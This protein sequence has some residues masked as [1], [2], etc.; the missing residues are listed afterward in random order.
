VHVILPWR[1]AG[2]WEA[3]EAFHRAAVRRSLALG[4]TASGE[5]G[6]GLG[7]TEFLADEHGAEAVAVMRSLKN[8]FDPRGILNPGKVLPADRP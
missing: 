2:E 3:V 6:V 1:T 7:K 8:L 5:H 4:G